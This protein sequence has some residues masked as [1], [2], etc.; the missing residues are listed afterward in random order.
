MKCGAGIVRRE[1]NRAAAGR[2]LDG[3][4]ATLASCSAGCE[5]IRSCEVLR[6]TR[7]ASAVNVAQFTSNTSGAGRITLPARVAYQPGRDAS[8]FVPAAPPR[9][10]SRVRGPAGTRTAG[11]GRANC[12]TGAPVRR[13]RVVQPAGVGQTSSP[14]AAAGPLPTTMSTRCSSGRRHGVGG[15]PPQAGQRGADE[16]TGELHGGHR[17]DG[18][19]CATVPSN[20]TPA[21]EVTTRMRPSPASTG[22]G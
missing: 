4:P 19:Q 6:G 8:R 18:G 16:G 12:R 7:H 20:A 21:P 13:L 10:V 11:R 14:A 17:P 15:R 1:L 22:V 5:N 3:R 9:L 2:W